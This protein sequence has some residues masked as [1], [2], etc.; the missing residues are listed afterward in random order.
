MKNRE[1]SWII[2]LVSIYL[3]VGILLTII[4]NTTPDRQAAEESKVFFCASHAIVAIMIGYGLALLSAYMATHYQNFRRWGLL[5]GGIALVLAFYCLVDAA[6]KLYFG[7]AGEISLGDLPHWVAKAF[8]KDQYGLPIFAN[9]IL[10]A[11]AAIFII[12]LTVYRQRGP[13]V[14]L[15]LMFTAM[16]VWSG[17]S[18]WY[19]SEQRNHWFGYW[20]GHDMFTPPFVGPDGK[21]SYDAKLRADATKGPNGDLVYPEMA[22]DAIVFGGTD[23]GRFCPTYM[24]FC[25]S[26]I[27]HSCQPLQ[28]QHFDRRDCYL[29]TQNALADGTYLDY[30]RSQYFRSQQQDPPFFREFVKLLGEKNPLVRSLSSLAYNVLDVPLTKFGAKVEAR[31]RA[32]GVYPPNEIYIPSPEDSQMCFQQ[33]TDDVAHRQA[34]GQLRQGE[35]VTVQNGRVQVSGQVAVMMINGLLCKVIFDRNPTNEFYIEESFPLDWMYPYETPFGVIMKINRNPLTSLPPDVF[36]RDHEFWSKFSE[37]LIG[38]WIT[39]DTKP[40]E[41]ADFSQQLYVGN[42]YAGFKGDRK[43]IRDDGGQKAFSKLRSSIAGV[44]AWRLG[45]DCPP[46]YRPKNDAETQALIKEADFAFKQAFAFCPYSP[47]AVYRYVNFL[48]QFQRMDDALIV[49]ETCIKLDPYNDQIKNLINQLKQFKAE[50]AT[51]G[52]VQ[53]QLQKLQSEAVAH[54]TNFQN[55]LTLGSLLTQMQETNRAAELFHQAAALFGQELNDP[56]ARPENIS[57]MAQIAALIG[58]YDKL[59]L[60]LKK[61]V[62]LLP[63][64]PEP[65][66]DLAALQAITGKNDESLKNLGTAIQMSSK[67]LLTNASARDLIVEARK[68]PRFNSVRNLPGFQK[69]VPNN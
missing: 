46:E 49:A 40:Q 54:P 22:R 47:E 34:L 41:I 57:A 30:L 56:K 20:F 13:V 58:D 50:S 3:C 48:L 32:E 38:N 7:P 10:V 53:D 35:D 52:Q 5:G 59:E 4:M 28:D 62:T 27:P 24:I 16:P 67:R 60:T 33:Y 64:Q 42:N 11:T 36:K 23:P 6:G 15:L 2:G 9:L 63:D 55:V 69:L 37:R 18:H 19:K 1:R 8:T 44:Y 68:D 26:F 14:I 39:Y 45:R 43:F 61:L 25:E 65:L 31:R 66:Y 29:I 51:R 21:L 17:L 12:A